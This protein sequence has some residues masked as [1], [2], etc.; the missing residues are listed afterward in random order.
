MR[1]ECSGVCT[2]YNVEAFNQVLVSSAKNSP[3]GHATPYFIVYYSACICQGTWCR[4]IF[5]LNGRE[6]QTFPLNIDLFPR[7]IYLGLSGIIRDNDPVNEIG[8]Y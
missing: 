4:L 1:L 2:P 6:Y 5:E 8:E 3:V 7:L